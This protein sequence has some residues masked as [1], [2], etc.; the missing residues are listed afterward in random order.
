MNKI[1]IF[2]CFGLRR[3]PKAELWSPS[4]VL[5]QHIEKQAFYGRMPIGLLR[6]IL[7]EIPNGS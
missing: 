1:G 3:R 5:S 2:L 4:S 6:P 7:I